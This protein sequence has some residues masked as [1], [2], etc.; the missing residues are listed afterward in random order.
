M[1]EALVVLLRDADQM[2]L[3]HRAAEIAARVPRGSL[4][5]RELAADVITD[6]YCGM[7]AGNSEQKL[8]SL[9]IDEVRRR[10]KRT[11]KHARKHVPIEQL[12]ENVS[13]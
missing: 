11:R 7:L 2:A 6:I 5:A 13:R 12:G 10:A 9:V 8:T 3:V 4:V 1:R